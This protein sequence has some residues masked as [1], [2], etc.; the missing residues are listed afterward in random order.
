MPPISLAVRAIIRRYILRA[1]DKFNSIFLQ[2][3][4]AAPRREIPKIGAAATAK[5]VGV[6]VP[7]KPSKLHYTHNRT[8]FQATLDRLLSY[9]FFCM[10]LFIMHVHEI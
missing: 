6:A 9:I 5:F 2:H 8:F 4:E 10:F 1:A 7:F 3:W